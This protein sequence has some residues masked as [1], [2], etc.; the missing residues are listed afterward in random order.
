MLK[1]FQI[2]DFAR[3]Q[4]TAEIKQYF[5]EERGEELG[6]L[7]AMLILEFFA[8][9]LAPHFY[10]KGIQDGHDFISQRLDDIFELNK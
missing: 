5:L 9:K 6:D 10:N 4:M 3:N 1:N 2:D 8:N 7:A